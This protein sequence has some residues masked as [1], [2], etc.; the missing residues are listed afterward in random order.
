MFCSSRI[1]IAFIV[2]FADIINYYRNAI[3]W[4]PLVIVFPWLC[5]I[6]TAAA[7]FVLAFAFAHH[8]PSPFLRNLLEAPFPSSQLNCS[9]IAL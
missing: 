5:V 6:D 7:L 9:P 4:D 2:R 8:P 1:G 3:T